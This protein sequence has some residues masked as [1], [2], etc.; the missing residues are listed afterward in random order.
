MSEQGDLFDE[1][2]AESSFSESAAMALAGLYSDEGLDSSALSGEERRLYELSANAFSAIA[3]AVASELPIAGE[4]ERFRGKILAAADA[5]GRQANAGAPA[6][7]AAAERAMRRAAEIAADD[8][9]DPDARAVYE[10]A[11][12]VHHEIARL[13]GFLRFGPAPDGV[14]CAACSPDHFVLPALAAYFKKRFGGAPWAIID[15]KRRLR[16]SHAPGRAFA[17]TRLDP[18]Q[19]APAP[20]AETEG[21]RDGKWEDLWRRYHSAINNPSRAN[22]GLQNSLI[23]RRY[24][25]YLTE[26]QPSKAGERDQET[27]DSA[28]HKSSD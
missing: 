22:P 16:L 3:H 13:R 8:R 17:L 23:P 2:G 21:A 18:R 4:I 11:H 9:V 12:K 7:G 6:S 19:N 25:K 27:D 15:E 26:M 24:R 28:S 10:A 1:G 14:Y 5:A 20:E